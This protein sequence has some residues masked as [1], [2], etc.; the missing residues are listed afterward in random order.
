[1]EAIF[2]KSLLNDKVKLHP[3]QLNKDSLQHILD[4]LKQK[5]EGI[6]SHHGYIKPGSIK[7]YKCSLGNVLA[8]SLNGDVE[9]K[10]QY[11]ADVCNPMIGSTIPT[12]VASMNKFGILA[13]AGF[14]DNSKLIPIIDMIV[15]R[16]TADPQAVLHMDTLVKGDH[17]NVEIVGK[18]FQLGDKKISAIGKLIDKSAS[19]N[20]DNTNEDGDNDENE[21]IDEED[22]SDHSS[23][24]SED[25]ES[26]EESSEEEKDEESEEASSEEIDDDDLDGLDEDADDDV[27][28]EVVASDDDK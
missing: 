26:E 20:L 2:V 6:C 10:I 13:Q 27:D 8:V 24:D 14:N 5:Y 11:Y 1:M 12:T 21:D 22:V 16:A 18:K 19:V 3:Y 17:I 23:S 7:I 15:V 25:E 28:D 9:Y 4:I